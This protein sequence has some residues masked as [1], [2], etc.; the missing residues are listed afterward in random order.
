MTSLART[1]ILLLALLLSGCLALQDLKLPQ[2]PPPAGAV[3]STSPS[4]TTKA[5][6]TNELEKPHAQNVRPTKR[7]CEPPTRAVGPFCLLRKDD[8]ND[9]LLAGM[10]AVVAGCCGYKLT[11]SRPEGG[12]I[13]S[14][15][16][17]GITSATDDYFDVLQDYRGNTGGQWSSTRWVREGDRFTAGPTRDLAAEEEVRE[18]KNDAQKVESAW[19]GVEQVGDD[20]AIK[21]FLHAFAVKHTTGARNARAAQRM[22]EHMKMITAESYCPAVKDFL[23][24][25]NRAEFAKRAKSHCD[26]S[27]PT[28]GGLNGEQVECRTECRAVFA[29]PCP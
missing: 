4:S 28:A 11:L 27:P 8:E 22:I 9:A 5:T 16:G 6:P 12:D 14:G 15:V 29:T 19:A 1:T 13:W 2:P 7:G 17:S 25:S 18:A 21:K 26:D 10:P 23:K 24:V 3:P 20:L